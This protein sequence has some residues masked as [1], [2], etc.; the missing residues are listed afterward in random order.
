M[1]QILE[2]LL[3]QRG[4][5][6]LA[7][8]NGHWFV[9][10]QSEEIAVVQVYTEAMLATVDAQRISQERRIVQTGLQKQNPLPCRFLTVIVTRR[11]VSEYLRDLAASLD[12]IWFLC[13]EEQTLYVFENQSVNYWELYDAL[14]QLAASGFS[15]VRQKQEWSAFLRQLKPV[16]VALVL[17]NSIIFLAAWCFGDVYDASYMYKIGGCTWRAVLEE[18]EYWRLFTSMFL[19]FGIAHLVSN[20]LSLIFLG[21]MLEE[22]IGRIR[23]L[24]VYLGSGILAGLA[25]V[26]WE[27]YRY[28][29]GNQTTVVSAGAS[30]AI[31]GVVGAL[32]CVVVL[33][34][35]FRKIK[36]VKQEIS[37]KNLLWMAAFT[38]LA[39]FGNAGVDNAAHIG[40]M[41]GGL[42]L[43][44]LLAI[45]V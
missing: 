35:H 31:F 41:A 44:L 25:S 4:F 8:G 6:R 45:K 28:L 37:L 30:G 27:R 15:K 39:G 33:Q 14:T 18:Q 7:Y 16:T 13:E 23:Y 17:L 26:G 12:G 38:L 22:W 11:G 42:L 9:R 43:A 3:A 10:G 2:Q 5:Q 32:I 29:H 36:G 20:M 34:K 40:G 21:S 19:H 1:L 24:V